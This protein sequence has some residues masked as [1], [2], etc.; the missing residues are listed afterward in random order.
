MNEVLSDTAMWALI[1]GAAQPLVLSVIMQ[2]KWSTKVQTLVAFLFSMVTG[3]GT[4]LFTGQF[5][6][7][8]II[9]SILLVAVV[10]ITSY[11]GFWKP[12]GTSPAIERATSVKE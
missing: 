8:S 5:T 9:S 3:T 4:A 6:G 2:S 10:S 7:L 12:S 11:K 1:V